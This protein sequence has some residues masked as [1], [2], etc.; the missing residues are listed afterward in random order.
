MEEWLKHPEWVEARNSP[1]KVTKNGLPLQLGDF[2]K[3]L[4]FGEVNVSGTREF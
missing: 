1:L 4:V 3:G 2:R